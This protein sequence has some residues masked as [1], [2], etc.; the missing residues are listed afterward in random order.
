M[1]YSQKRTDQEWLDTIQ[2]VYGLEKQNHSFIDLANYLYITIY[3][4]LRKRHHVTL[5][6]R[7]LSDEDL[8]ALAEEI[9]QRF[10]EKMIKDRFALLQKYSGRGSFLVWAAQVV[11]NL[12]RSELR[13]PQWRILEPLKNRHMQIEYDGILPEDNAFHNLL[14][15]RLA[16]CLGYLPEHYQ[17]AL[18]EC[19]IEG[20]KA[21]EVGKALD[22]SANAVHILVHRAKKMMRRYLEDEG[23]GTDLSTILAH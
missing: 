23:V 17:F 16:H 21:E 13:R 22:I 3:N 9:L 19:V 12:C 10:M 15:D 6:L 5:G 2:G 8:A 4:C 11:L 7:H 14:S 20:R 1:G 18:V